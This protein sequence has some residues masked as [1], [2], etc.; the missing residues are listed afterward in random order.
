MLGKRIERELRAPFTTLVHGD[1]NA[2]NILFRLEEERVFY[3]DVHRSCYGDY[4]QDISVF[5]I[6]NFRVPI[7]SPE[8]R[9][10]LNLANQR[11][12]ACAASYADR[13]KDTT[14]DARLALGLFRSL[15]TSTR[16]VFD[17]EISN[18]F[19]ERASI[20]MHELNA[21]KDNLSE[22]RLN[23]ELFLYN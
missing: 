5:L 16:F 3:V 12:Y 7:F 15:I 6:S 10:R 8:I 22:F 17:Q 18:Q 9:Q 20:I 21:H 11:V 4:V 14:F 23:T 19:I 1:F 2:D 13:Q